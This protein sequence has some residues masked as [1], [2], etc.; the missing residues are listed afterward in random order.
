VCRRGGIGRGL[1]KVGREDLTRVNV[2]SASRARKTVST[3]PPSQNDHEERDCMSLSPPRS[4]QK[5]FISFPSFLFLGFLDPF[6]LQVI[7]K[8]AFEHPGDTYQY[9]QRARDQL[10]GLGGLDTKAIEDGR[11][12]VS[13]PDR[14]R[15]HND[16][17]G[18]EENRCRRCISGRS[19]EKEDSFVQ[20]VGYLDLKD[21]REGGQGKDT[22]RDSI[23]SSAIGDGC[24]AY[25][26]MERR[27]AR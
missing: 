27:L 16:V 23:G 4:F 1:Y 11:T 20:I 14:A 19:S 26:M 24:I 8:R 25:S 9:D 5:S 6:Q 18:L 7:R 17:S 3:P 15:K 10:E 22:K 13:S 2:D 21:R 12:V